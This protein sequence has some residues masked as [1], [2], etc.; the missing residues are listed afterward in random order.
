MLARLRETKLLLPTLMVA[1]ALPL[2]TWLGFWQLDR[3]AWKE[4]LL[5]A[6]ADRSTSAPVP[7][8]QA[9]DQA[10][11][12]MPGGWGDLEYKHVSMRGRFLNDKEMYLYAP[13]LEI[14]PGFQVFTPFVLAEAGE[15]LIVN[16][17]FVPE[18]FKD[19]ASR[20][21]GQIAGETDVA[22]LIRLPGQHA[23]F[24]PDNDP[25]A[26][27]W[28]WRDFDGMIAA[29]Y[30]ANAEP[31]KLIPLFVDAEGAAPGGWPRGGTT[32]LALP[33]RHLEYAMTWFGLAVALAAIYILYAIQRIN[34]PRPSDD[35]A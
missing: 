26:N 16:R 3:L 25:K 34:P 1:V 11:G 28:F 9:L 19:P 24:V 20:A 32:L 12:H 33:N 27:L 21:Q 5:Q 35:R 29:S 31:A 4:S 18:Q 22:G 23:R 2:L 10:A 30:P 13:S 8:R 6:I 7:I 15:T 17:G 14:G